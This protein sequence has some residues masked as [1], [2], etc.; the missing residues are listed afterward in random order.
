[1][2]P[3]DVTM[4]SEP[5]RSHWTFLSNHGHVLVCIATNPSIRGRE[6]AEAVGITERAAQSIV[7]DLVADGYVTK[8]KVGRQ[9]HYRVRRS[10]R[11][12]HEIE[13]HVSVGELL[14]LID[15]GS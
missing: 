7:A 14:G 1:M 4:A 9:N 12:R 10:K 13:Q 11:L 8:K 6:I 3:Y 5:R 15:D 2:S